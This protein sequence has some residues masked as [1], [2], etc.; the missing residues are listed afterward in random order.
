VEAKHVLV[1]DDDVMIRNCMTEILSLEGFEVYSA[2][3]GQDALD[4]LNSLSPEHLP[5]CIILDLKMPVMDGVTFLSQIHSRYP[6]TFAR[7]PIIVASAN[8]NLN[9]M[10]GL[11]EAAER[12]DKPVDF[13]DICRVAAKYCGTPTGTYLH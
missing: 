1:V 2:I 4:Q 11:D 9:S 6:E 10:P 3:H 12:L 7:I 13:D 5:G 8:G